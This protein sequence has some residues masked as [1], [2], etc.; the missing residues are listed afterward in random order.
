M[1]GSFS[2]GCFTVFGSSLDL[3]V[4][5][6]LL[7]SSAWIA[8]ALRVPSSL[9]TS[10]SFCGTAC[11]RASCFLR[12]LGDDRLVGSCSASGTWLRDDGPA[13]LRPMMLPFPSAIE[14]R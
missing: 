8:D 3:G 10:G 2:L 6:V 9:A 11:C 14:L 12:S 7:S 1:A 4:F 13:S 5:R